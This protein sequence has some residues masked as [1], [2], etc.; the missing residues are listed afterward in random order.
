[1]GRWILR[2]GRLLGALDAIAYW[3]VWIALLF[4]VFAQS[5]GSLI[6]LVPIAPLAAWTHE[7][8]TQI[9][10]VA[11]TRARWRATLPPTLA[12]IAIGLGVHPERWQLPFLIAGGAAGFA[13][14]LYR[15]ALAWRVRAFPVGV[16]MLDELGGASIRTK[17]AVYSLAALPAGVAPGDLVTLP[18]VRT[19]EG[20]AG[21]YRVGPTKGRSP[22]LWRADG[23]GMARALVTSGIA[24]L[25]WGAVTTAWAFL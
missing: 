3:P 13:A 2:P 4:V 22:E 16:A 19:F 5:P 23:S 1:M 10:L 7:A 11:V 12:L 18:L 25:A 6:L 20:G 14:G 24:G 9:D 8:L 17:S 15:L 21:P